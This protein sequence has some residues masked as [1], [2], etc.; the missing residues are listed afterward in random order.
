M[1]KAER[2]AKSGRGS[3]PD[4]TPAEKKTSDIIKNVVPAPK[5]I[6]FRR[7]PLCHTRTAASK[8]NIATMTIEDCDSTIH[9]FAWAIG[10]VRLSPRNVSRP[11][12]LIERKLT[13]WL[14]NRFATTTK[15]RQPMTV[16][17]SQ[18]R[19]P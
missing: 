17:K 9:Q 16:Q 11:S 12:D 2:D 6:A 7:S 4:K 13:N 1:Q 3:R 10:Y 15:S 14:A 19:P 5:T 18:R 8:Q